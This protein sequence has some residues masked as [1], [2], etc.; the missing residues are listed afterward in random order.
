[1]KRF[2]VKVW[3]DSGYLDGPDVRFSIISESRLDVEDFVGRV[4]GENK[5]FV[6]MILMLLSWKDF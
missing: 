2:A 4:F 3:V 6:V 1:M 5:H